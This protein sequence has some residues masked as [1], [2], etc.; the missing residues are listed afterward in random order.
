MILFNY[1]FSAIY[2]VVFFLIL[3]IFHPLQWLAITLFGYKAHKLV[4]D[5][6]NICLVKSL[7]V[8]GVQV[9]FENNHHLPKGVPLI[10]VAN[11]QS[12]FDIP[13]LIWYFRKFHPKFVAKIELGKGIP[14]ISY[15]L[16]HGGA[17]LIDR[18]D[19]KQSLVEISKFA[20]RINKN[21]WSAVIFPEGTRSKNGKP[22]KFSK[23]GLKVLAKK[24][25]N[26]Y[27]VPITINNS[28]E[29]FKF[30]KFPFGMGKPIQ[31]TTHAPIA[32]DSMPIDEC[33]ERVEEIITK[34]IN[35]Q[36]AITQQ[37]QRSYARAR[38]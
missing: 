28:W 3:V 6:M 9:Q 4:V 30:G 34:S 10:F 15:N 25:P 36:H 37:A 24:C 38:S 12:L 35:P 7:L 16:R 20:K 32:I 31:V 17:A 2:A 14:S 8:L 21:T 26:A 29:I 1:F 13:P 19:P 11:H 5:L 33:I 27:I 23:N 22:R 18:K